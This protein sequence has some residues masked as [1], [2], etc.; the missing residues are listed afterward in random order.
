ME[1]LRQP[2]FQFQ[3]VRVGENGAILGHP[4]SFEKNQ[5]N[6][7]IRWCNGKRNFPLPFS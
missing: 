2:R 4:D 5:L 1:T 3:V 6:F 7:S